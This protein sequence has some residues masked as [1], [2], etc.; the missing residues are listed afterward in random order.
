M[1]HL[2]FILLL[3]ICGTLCSQSDVGKQ[4]LIVTTDL[5]GADPDDKQSL[6]HLLVCADRVDLEGI[7]SSNAWV[8]DPDRTSDIMEVID[9]YSAIYPSLKRHSKGFPDVNYL[10]SIVKRG[11]EKSNMSGVGEGKDSPGSELIIAAVD[12]KDDSRPV[13]LAAW[14]G[15]NTIA[16]AIWKVHATRSPEEFQEFAAKIRIYDVLGQDDAGAWIAKSF[17]EI[18]YIRNKEIYGWGPSD[19][20]IKENVQSKKPF[21]TCYPDRIWAS[22]GDSP[23]FLYVYAN[24]LN[25]PDSLTYGG[26]GGRFNAERTAGIRGMDFIEK[27]GKNEGMYDPYFMHA[28]AKEGIAA[29]NKWRQ[30]ILND[31]AARMN[32]T[33]TDKFS[34]ANHHP[35]AVIENDST[36]NCLNRVVKAGSLWVFDATSSYDS[37]GDELDYRWF[38]YK[39][40]S[41]YKGE[42]QLNVDE[43]GICCL[44]MPKEASGKNIHL[45]LELSD[46]GVP[47]LTSY[48]RIVIHVK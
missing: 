12:K 42:V 28:S 47:Q 30:H 24:G 22:E 32:W 1:R 2:F 37:D 23:S 6:I 46:S 7:I 4:R 31:F 26:W 40:P 45:I 10:R 19:E 13:W 43:Q 11:Q 25:V 3:G 33:T 48:R 39:E 8:D 38:V 17:P 15:M 35:V 34:E 27:S 44:R 41:S 16:Q 14:S 21:G 20:W 9:C 18:Y 36:F 29:I 5:G